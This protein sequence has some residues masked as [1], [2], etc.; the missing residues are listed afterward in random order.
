MV[1]DKNE[2]TVPGFR[3]SAMSVGLKKN[4]A[5]DIAMIVC[6]G[7]ISPYTWAGVRYSGKRAR[8]VSRA[9]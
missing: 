6:S 7:Y 1:A 4:K 9:E 8:K 5:L 2:M 3:A